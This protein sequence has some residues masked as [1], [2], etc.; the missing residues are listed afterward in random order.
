MPRRPT[1]LH[2]VAV[3]LFFPD[4]R[5]SNSASIRVDAPGVELIVLLHRIPMVRRETP[6]LARGAG[7]ALSYRSVS[8]GSRET[9]GRSLRPPGSCTT[10]A[11]IE[12]SVARHA[13]PARL[14]FHSNRLPNP[15]HAPLATHVS[16][17]SVET[18]G[19]GVRTGPVRADG[20]APA[21]G[22]PARA[23]K[24]WSVDAGEGALHHVIGTTLGVG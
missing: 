24:P 7:G 10:P 1:A 22:G 14:V 15:L 23:G 6:H 5:L 9:L 2:G 18:D 11:C 12:R 19:D 13:R 17:R 8:G 16:L 4:H 20:R 3:L 21:R